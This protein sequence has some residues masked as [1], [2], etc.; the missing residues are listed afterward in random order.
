MKKGVDKS[1]PLR[2][3]ASCSEE[4]TPNAGV[5]HP[6]ERHLAKVEVASSSLVTRSRKKKDIRSDVLL[7]SMK[8]ACGK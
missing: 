1:E 2:Y 7:F 3:N 6:V 8:F 5:A 4:Q